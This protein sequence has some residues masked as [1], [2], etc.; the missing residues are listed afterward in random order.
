MIKGSLTSPCFI[1][2]ASVCSALTD[3]INI[4]HFILCLF[5]SRKCNAIFCCGRNED[6][7]LFY[8]ALNI[9]VAMHVYRRDET[10][11]TIHSWLFISVITP[12]QFPIMVYSYIKLLCTERCSSTPEKQSCQCCTSSWALSE[13][14]HVVGSDHKLSWTYL[15]IL[16][17]RWLQEAKVARGLDSHVNECSNKTPKFNL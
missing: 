12:G 3:T 7:F 2:R 5:N 9:E 11:W 15:E 8:F 1:S 6:F 16:Y 10:G 13:Y 17:R 14:L 4:H